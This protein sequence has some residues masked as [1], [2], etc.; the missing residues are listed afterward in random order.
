MV[1][2]A[3]GFLPFARR[4]LQGLEEAV[5]DERKQA[6]DATAETTHEDLVC[7]VAASLIVGCVMTGN[8]FYFGFAVGMSR[9]AGCW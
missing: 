8:L 6:G 2:E 4:N 5:P 3:G 9:K 1:N 7:G